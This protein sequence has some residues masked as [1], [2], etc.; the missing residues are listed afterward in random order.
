M[1][2][3]IINDVDSFLQKLEQFTNATDLDVWATAND[4]EADQSVNI[5]RLELMCDA[6][7]E[8]QTAPQPVE[9]AVESNECADWFQELQN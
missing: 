8:P 6:V 5:R 4:L 7:D 2:S 3:R 1:D 9:S